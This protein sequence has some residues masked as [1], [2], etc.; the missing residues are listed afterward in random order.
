MFVHMNNHYPWGNLQSGTIKDALY[1]A[2]ALFSLT[3]KDYVNSSTDNVYSHCLRVFEDLKTGKTSC[4]SLLGNT[5]SFPD[6]SRC[7]YCGKKKATS[8][9]H[10]IPQYYGGREHPDNLAPCCPG[11][12]SSKSNK[13]LIVWASTYR[14][15]LSLPLLQRYLEQLIPLCNDLKIMEKTVSDIEADSTLSFKFDALYNAIGVFFNSTRQPSSRRREE[16]RSLQNAIELYGGSQAQGLF[17]HFR[18]CGIDN[19]WDLTEQ[20]LISLH[21]YLLETLSPST[22]KMYSASICSLLTKVD[23]SLLPYKDYRNILYIGRDDI[24]KV[25]LTYEEMALL[26]KVYLKS[27]SEKLV[28]YSFLLVDFKYTFSNN[29]ISS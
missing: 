4:S 22:A 9:D 3:Q 7:V 27:T 28:T 1:W 13:D 21:D 14:R 16:P 17:K 2:C 5:L 29:A 20:N 6:A 25:I 19:W 12:N 8:V 26:E 23:E 10:I 15:T 11:C 24:T 18:A